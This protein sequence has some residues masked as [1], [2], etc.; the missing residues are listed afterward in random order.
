MHAHAWGLFIWWPFQ[1]TLLRLV[2]RRAGLACSRSRAPDA[3]VSACGLKLF[4]A[5]ED[6]SQRWVV[7]VNRL[8]LA[9]YKMRYVWTREIWWRISFLHLPKVNQQAKQRCPPLKVLNYITDPTPWPLTFHPTATLTLPL[10]SRTSQTWNALK[11]KLIF[12][13][14]FVAK[15]NDQ[16]WPLPP[17]HTHLL[18][19]PHSYV[20]NN[21][22]VLTP[23]TL[24]VISAP[25]QTRQTLKRLI[26][27][28][29]HHWLE[30]ISKQVSAPPPA[31]SH[32][33]PPKSP[34]CHLA[35]AHQNSIV[36]RQS[37]E[38]YHLVRIAESQAK[39]T[40]FNHNILRKA[41]NRQNVFSV[42]S[43]NNPTSKD[44]VA[45]I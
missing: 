21:S 27:A 34:P 9:L 28:P 37:K 31:G 29:R 11:C 44:S 13:A 16:L 17:P 22:W 14:R 40:Y 38:I 45:G 6:P 4:W 23:G 15:H 3:F 30:K 36:T 2:V 18:P 5:L 7:G 32:L 10:A 35:L 26:T 19:I 25:A 12:C 33:W 39:V 24:L 42:I 41:S 43:R 8:W 1:H 20:S